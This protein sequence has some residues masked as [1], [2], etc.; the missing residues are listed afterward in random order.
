MEKKKVTKN[1]ESEWPG[2]WKTRK[3]WLPILKENDIQTRLW[4]SCLN[5]ILKWKAYIYMQV[6]QNILSSIFSLRKISFD[7]LY[8][9]KRTNEG[10]WGSRV[11]GNRKCN[12]KEMWRNP[13]NYGKRKRAVVLGCRLYTAQSTLLYQSK[14]QKLEGCL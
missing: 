2:S 4:Q 10:R 6:L 8:L 7:V 11:T 5:I 13:Q 3:Q 9:N 1:Q 14:S 12:T